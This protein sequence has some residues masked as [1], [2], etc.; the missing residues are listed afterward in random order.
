MHRRLPSLLVLVALSFVPDAPLPAQES[1]MVPPLAAGQRTRVTYR[2]RLR[3]TFGQ[4][5]SADSQALAIRDQR[6]NYVLTIPW[7]HIAR[8][9]ASVGQRSASRSVGRGLALGF[10]SGAGLGT[11]AFIVVEVIGTEEKCRCDAT[12]PIRNLTIVATPVTTVL[13]G[14]LGAVGDREIWQRVPT[15]VTPPRLTIGPVPGGGVG[16]ALGFG[17]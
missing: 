7:E 2:Q 15:P 9:D 12:A 11:M 10:L 3:P 8:L 1:E 16:F 5:V 4:F 13:G 17:W 14:I 6:S